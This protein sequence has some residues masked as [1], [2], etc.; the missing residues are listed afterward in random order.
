MPDSQSVA[1]GSFERGPQHGRG[2]SARDGRTREAA[3]EGR[4][5]TQTAWQQQESQVRMLII[6]CHQV[7]IRQIMFRIMILIKEYYVYYFLPVQGCK[8][9]R[10][11]GGAKCEKQFAFVRC[12]RGR[13]KWNRQ[14]WTEG[15]SGWDC[16]PLVKLN[17]F[18]NTNIIIRNLNLKNLMQPQLMTKT[19]L[20]ESH[21]NLAVTEWFLI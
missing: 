19:E 21:F 8:I 18:V 6:F 1:G 10:Q 16:L 3:E 4:T 11:L 20:A 5:A 2:E 17:L 14:H 13:S 9:T 12:W 7:I 15:R